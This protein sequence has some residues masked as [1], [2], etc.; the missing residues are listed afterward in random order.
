MT[1][2]QMELSCARYSADDPATRARSPCRP[3]YA[4]GM[5]ADVQADDSGTHELEAANSGQPTRLS[6]L[7]TW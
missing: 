2:M 3:M 7:M 5:V 6:C 1:C 4:R